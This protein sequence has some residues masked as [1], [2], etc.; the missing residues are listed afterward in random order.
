[1]TP[2]TLPHPLPDW[3]LERYALGELSADK[4]AAVK[5]RLDSVPEEAERLRLLRADNAAFAVQ[6]PARTFA[7]AIR[8]R[9]GLK[10]R[11]GRKAVWLA[12]PALALAAA[13]MLVVGPGLGPSQPDVLSKG[14]HGAAAESVGAALH[15][16]REGDGELTPGA[17]AAQGDVLGFRFDVRDPGFGALFSIDGAGVVTLHLPESVAQGPIA[18]EPGRTTV[19]LGYELDDAPGYER[20]FLVLAQ[21]PFDLDAVLHAAERLATGD[22]QTGRL[23]LPAELDVVD[24]VVTKPAR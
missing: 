5:A 8:A 11:S 17:T 7:P 2:P 10:P 12:A 9:A 4:L 15:L 20:F 24:F 14:Q 21:Q 3:L 16:H 13:W 19:D 22:G 6:Y 1:M 23:E 18:V